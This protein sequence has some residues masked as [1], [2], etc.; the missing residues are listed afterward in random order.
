MTW[1]PTEWDGIK[2][3]RIP[4]DWL[5]VPDV[6]LINTYVYN[7]KFEFEIQI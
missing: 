1:D 7:S 4:V 2:Y 6:S 3:V 5:W